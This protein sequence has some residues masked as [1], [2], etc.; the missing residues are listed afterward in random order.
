MITIMDLKFYLQDLI[1][2]NPG[3]KIMIQFQKVY[4]L[5]MMMTFIQLLI[6]PKVNAGHKILKLLIRP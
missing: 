4:L 2:L 3:L 5:F 1:M 6:I